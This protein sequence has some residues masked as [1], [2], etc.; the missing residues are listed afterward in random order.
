MT[1][2]SPPP[3][4]RQ[5]DAIASIATQTPGA[6]YV[7]SVTETSLYSFTIPA[8]TMAIG[9]TYGLS[10]RGALIQTAATASNWTWRYRIGGVAG[11]IIC[12]NPAVMA[13]PATI[14]G[15]PGRLLRID[16]IL[17][18]RATGAT[19]SINGHSQARLPAMTTVAATAAA[20]AEV[21]GVMIPWAG[22]A[23]AA[24][25]SGAVAI[26]T[27]LAQ[28]IHITAVSGTAVA[29]TSVAFHAGTVTLAK[30]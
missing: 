8:N 5:A 1:F 18:C 9:T 20:Y 2:I 13:Y 7:A 10:L 29:G 25:M 19:G 15:A 27:T 21:S 17:T 22:A 14:F 23:A 26:D 28:T 11:T 4:T 16:G 3:G 24:T 12:Q 30:L 6:P